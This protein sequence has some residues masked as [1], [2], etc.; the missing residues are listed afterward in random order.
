M[1][2]LVYTASTKLKYITQ[3]L[4]KI[5]DEGTFEFGL[6]GVRAWIMSPD[7]TSL[8]VLEM[9]SLS[10]DEYSVEEEMRVVLRTDELNKIVR[11]A[12]RNDDVI[13]KY[14]V[15]EQ[16][17][18]VELRDRKLGFSRS[19]LVP[20]SSMGAEE[21]RSLKL[22]PTARFSILTDDFKTVIQDV[23]VV[24][25]FAEFEASGDTLTVRSQAEEREYEWVMR[26][27]DALLSIEVD[28]EARSTYS[29]QV[30]EIATKP[31][32][33]S[34]AVKVSF[35]SDYPMKIEFTFPNGERLE[36]YIAPSLG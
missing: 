5:N 36:L 12:T 8:A 16:A 20:I 21:I 14:S 9:P 6:N 34:E 1:F 24:G 26:P 19:F 32:G 25:D 28:E 2:R 15:E 17:L 29:R 33:A 13:L 31:V 4:A 3:T 35:A 27:G 22:E 18:E 10:F 11:R 23:K 7:K 30:L